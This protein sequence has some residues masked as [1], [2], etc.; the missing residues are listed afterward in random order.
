MYA[1]IES[2]SLL[3]I[4]LNQQKLGVEEYIQLR[5]AITNDRKVTDID[6]NLILPATYI[7][8]PRHMHEYAQDAITYVRSYGRP[9]L[10]IT[11][12]CYTAWSEIKEELAH[13]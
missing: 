9:D 4:K 12:T 7:G 11:F 10:F 2:E 1:K 6:R 5:D 3:Y 13:R 8:S